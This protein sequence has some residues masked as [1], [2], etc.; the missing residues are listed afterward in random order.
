MTRKPTIGFIRVRRRPLYSRDPRKH[1]GRSFDIV[2]AV[3]ID[4]Q[5]THE[6]V[7][8][9]GSLNETRPAAFDVC[10]FWLGA[11]DRMK[12]HGLSPNKRRKFVEAMVTKGVQRPT[13]TQIRNYQTQIR[14][15][16][17]MY[18]GSSYLQERRAYLRGAAELIKYLKTW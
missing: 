13:I 11:L 15:T 5:P 18:R 1:F 4:G 12:R 16:A 8:G 2:R 7:L 14:D 3:R 6:F 17:A 10:D 9:L